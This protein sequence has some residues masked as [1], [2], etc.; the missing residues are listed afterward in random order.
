[1]KY[2]EKCECCG[3]VVTAYTHRLNVPL[4]KALRKLVDY[5]EKYHLACN[6]QKSLDLTH[7]QLANFQK[8]QYFGLVYGAKGG[9]IP[10]EEGIKFIHGEVT[11]MDIVATMANQVLSYDHKAWETHSKEPMAVN[12]S[13]IDYYSYK[14]REEYQAEK[15]PQANLF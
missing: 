9:W 5:F 10:T 1:M 14:R 6:L 12:I 7:N 8:L 11:C 13:D 4:V 15:S 2:Q 3:G